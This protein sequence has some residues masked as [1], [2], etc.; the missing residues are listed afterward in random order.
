[1][2]TFREGRAALVTA[3]GVFKYM[4]LYSIIQFTTVLILYWVTRYCIFG[5]NRIFSKFKIFDDLYL[6]L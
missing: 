3:F 1:M 6:I 4:A 5:I 2:D